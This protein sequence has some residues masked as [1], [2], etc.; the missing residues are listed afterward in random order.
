MGIKRFFKNKIKDYQFIK[1]QRKV[2]ANLQNLDF[3]KSH[4]FNFSTEINPEVSIIIHGSNDLKMIINCLHHIEKYD[5]NI[6]KEIFVIH[7]KSSE[8]QQYLENVKDITLIN[9]E[10]SDGLTQAINHSIEKAKGKFIYLLDSH[11]LVQENY[12]SSLLEVFNTKER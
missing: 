11:A 8:V 1:N 5:Q 4:P 2:T 6:S 12:L 3:F 7:D 10:E 9:K